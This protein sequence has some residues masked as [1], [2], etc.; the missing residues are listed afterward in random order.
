MARRRGGGSLKPERVQERLTVAEARER[1]ESLPDW[2]LAP[3]G[4]SISRTIPLPSLALTVA[5]L[6]LVAAL[7][8]LSGAAPELELRAGTLT[9]RLGS[10]RAGLYESE[11]EIAEGVEAGVSVAGLR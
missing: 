1:L 6:D 4:R 10:T 7:A 5:F 11:L 2:E 8:E 9:V 3:D